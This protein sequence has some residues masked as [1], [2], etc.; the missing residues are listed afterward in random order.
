M[1][2]SARLEQVAGTKLRVRLAGLPASDAAADARHHG[3][4]V[5]LAQ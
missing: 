5:D 4:I 3:A 2:E 1:V